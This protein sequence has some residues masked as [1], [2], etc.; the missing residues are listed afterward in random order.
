M[1]LRNNSK[2]MIIN[3]FALPNMTTKLTTQNLQ[4][5]RPYVFCA[6]KWMDPLAWEFELPRFCLIAFECLIA[7]SLLFEG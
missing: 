5:C 4:S 3:S 1:A 6:T 2:S 7:A